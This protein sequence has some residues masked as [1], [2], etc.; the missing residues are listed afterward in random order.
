LWDRLPKDWVLA[1][2]CLWLAACFGGLTLAGGE[3]LL[4]GWEALFGVGWGVAIPL[5]YAILF[6]LS[7]ER[8]RPLNTNLANEAFQGGFLLGPAL[9][10]LAL[11]AWRAEAVFWLAGAVCLACAGALAAG[12][13]RGRNLENEA[14]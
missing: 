1:A 3:A 2:A 8:L 13:A 12:A 10:G 11:A 4:L 7:P 9:G 14:P 5:L 6:E